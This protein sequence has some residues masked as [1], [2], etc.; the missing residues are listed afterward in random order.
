[1]MADAQ[2]AVLLTQ[3]APA[4]RFTGASADGLSGY[5]ERGTGAAQRCEPGN[6]SRRRATGLCDLHVGVDG[7]AEGSADPA[8]GGS[9]PAGVDATRLRDLDSSDVLLAVT[10]LSFDIA[11]L[12]LFLPLLVGA[13]LVVAS[14]ETAAD[15]AQLRR[16]LQQTGATVMQATPATWR[17]LQEAGWEGSAELQL[18]CG[19]EALL[20]ELASSYASA[21]ARCGICT[22]RRRRRSGRAFTRWR[23]R[24]KQWG[25]ASPLGGRSRTR[26]SICWTSNCGRCRWA[27]PGSC[28]SAATGWR[29]ATW[30]R[31]D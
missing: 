22:G 12:E 25:Q 3:A 20:P 11:A 8:S 15:G 26:R 29:A 23:R 5:C 17:M 4:G 31:P 24:R 18:W 10:T 6:Q 14:R 28:T 19:G 21:A 27:W 7:D 2:V 30:A 9:Q 1:M 16:Q 13:R